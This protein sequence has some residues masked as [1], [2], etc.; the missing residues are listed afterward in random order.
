MGKSSDLKIRPWCPFCRQT[1][2][3]PVFPKERSMQE[4]AAG[5]CDCGAHY[6][7]DPTGWN[8]GA[9]MIEC[10]LN[11]CGGNWELAW[12]LLPGEDYLTDQIDAYDEV[13]DRVVDTRNL[14]GRKIKG[15]LFFVRLQRELAELVAK[16]GE[17]GGS[18]EKEAVGP[19]PVEPERDPKRVRQKAT[20]PLVR[21]LVEAR[22]VDGLVDLV[23]DDTKTLQF[24]G[25]LLYDPRE[26][27][28]YATAHVIGS[29]CARFATRQPGAVSNLLQRL[30]DSCSDS[31]AANWGSVETIGE[32]IAAR[33]DIFGSFTRFL[34]NFIQDGSMGPHV[35]WALGTIAGARPE[36]VR[37]TPFYHLFVLLDAENPFLRGMAVRVLGRIGATEVAG[38]IEKLVTD[39]Q[40][41]TYYDKGQPVATTVGRL[42]REALDLMQQKGEQKGD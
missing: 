19:V 31:A 5:T 8:L 16:L 13:T 36:L 37:R 7:S 21:K 10:L 26:E 18:E 3:K 22:D 32:I 15:V 6:V 30:F 23:F 14:D 41:L 11:A 9:A 38:R 42:A 27:V 25:R 35:L 29:V 20:K 24:M 1:V 39:E 12:D 34:F 2:G 33:P 28:R 40:E 17:A 4:F